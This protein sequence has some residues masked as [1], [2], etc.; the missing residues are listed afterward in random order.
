MVRGTVGGGSKSSPEAGKEKA[1]LQSIIRDK[2]KTKRQ[3]D[4]AQAKLDKM[5]TA[6]EAATKTAKEAAQ[7]N[8]TAQAKREKSF[9]C[10]R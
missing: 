10:E 9:W 7:T 2:S 1:R 4:A 8:K 3:R 6:D 5:R